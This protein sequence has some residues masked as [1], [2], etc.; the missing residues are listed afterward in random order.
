MNSNALDLDLLTQSDLLDA[1]WYVENY[2][3]VAS[4]GL[5]AAEHYLH[6]GTLMLRDPGPRFST[7]EYLEANPD[8]A[9]AK[10]NALLHYLRFGRKEGRPLRAPQ[11][12]AQPVIS[13]KLPSEL[14]AS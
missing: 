12:N 5:P 1:N 10:T 14:K 4:L 6:Y 11:V 13:K 2:P 3:D 9:T 7:R 8:V